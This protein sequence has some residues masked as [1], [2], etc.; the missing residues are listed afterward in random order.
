[1][2]QYGAVKIVNVNETGRGV[3]QAGQLAEQ[4]QEEQYLLSYSPDVLTFVDW[5]LDKEH[6]S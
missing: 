6:R 2:V 3:M 4:A 5:M 1:M